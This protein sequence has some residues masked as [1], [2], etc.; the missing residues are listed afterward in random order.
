MTNKKVKPLWRLVGCSD[1]LR[2]SPKHP[3]VP[4]YNRVLVNGGMSMVLQKHNPKVATKTVPA[5]KVAEKTVP[6][7]KTVAVKTVGAESGKSGGA[8][9]LDKTL[10]QTAADMTVNQAKAAQKALS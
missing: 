10:S 5:K 7:K 8:K 6:A 4:N 1:T 9:P 2:A 3:I